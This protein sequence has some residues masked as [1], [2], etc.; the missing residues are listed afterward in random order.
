[1]AGIYGDHS[2]P[3]DRLPANNNISLQQIN[4]CLFK[5]MEWVGKYFGSNLESADYANYWGHSDESRKADILFG[6]TGSIA[7]LD[8]LISHFFSGAR[9]CWN[10]PVA[11][12]LGRPII[13]AIPTAESYFHAVFVSGYNNDGTVVYFDPQLG[14]YNPI[15]PSSLIHPIQIGNIKP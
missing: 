2:L 15:Q 11:I 3:Q 6:F 1:M 5:T 12:T 14:T 8:E 10:V 4:H 7:E 9:D 13:A